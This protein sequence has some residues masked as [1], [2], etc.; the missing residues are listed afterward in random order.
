MHCTEQRPPQHHAVPAQK[1]P[2]PENVN[3]ER[4]HDEE[5]AHEAG[6][7]PRRRRRVLVQVGKDDSEKH[8]R[9]KEQVQNHDQASPAIVAQHPAIGVQPPSADS[10][11]SASAR[12]PRRIQPCKPTLNTSPKRCSIIGAPLSITPGSDRRVG[13]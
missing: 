10:L 3:H 8:G 1:H 9:P 13:C 12:R 7:Q 6:D 5:Y 2:G 4:E 11:R